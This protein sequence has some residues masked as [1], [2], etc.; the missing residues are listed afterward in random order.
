VNRINA[1]MNNLNEPCHVS[2]YHSLFC[3]LMC[4]ILQQYFINKVEYL[5]FNIVVVHIGY[6]SRLA[7]VLICA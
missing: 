3:I 7:T 4:E 5:S 6:L 1:D 2:Y